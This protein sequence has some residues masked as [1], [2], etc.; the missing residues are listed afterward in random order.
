LKELDRLKSEMVRMTSHDLKN[1]LQAAMANVELLREDLV[2]IRQV[3]ML[4]SIDEIDWQLQRMT[5]IIRGVLDLERVKNGV[6]RL[7]SCSPARMIE[8]AAGELRQFAYSHGVQLNVW[9]DEKLPY[10]KCD[11]EQFKQA[12]VNLIENAIKFT[13]RGGTVRISA[14]QREQSVVFEVADNGVGIPIDVQ[15]RIFDRFYRVQRKGTEHITGSGLGLS[16]VKA[17]VDNH[18]GTIWL[19]STVGIGSTFYISLPVSAKVSYSQ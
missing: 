19:E 12:L 5:R 6:M 11:G 4:H 1:P 9:L 17:V 15:P 3:E 16:L 2:S 18:R 14:K 10:I 13:G 8:E 7:E